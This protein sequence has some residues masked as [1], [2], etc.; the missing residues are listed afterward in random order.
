MSEIGG[1]PERNVAR[2]TLMEARQAS[3]CGRAR[4]ASTQPSGST[5]RPGPPQLRSPM[6]RRR[7][8]TPRWSS[9]GARRGRWSARLRKCAGP[10]APTRCGPACRRQ[11]CALRRPRGCD[12]GAACRSPEIGSSLVHRVHMPGVAA[13]PLHACMLAG[14]ALELC[15]SLYYS[16]RNKHPCC[17]ALPHS[18]LIAALHQSHGML[19]NCNNWQ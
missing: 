2:V 10:R 14:R 13:V 18:L 16:M 12:G 1:Q 4:R 19:P 5:R 8:A 3:C 11:R 9:T 17:Q 7:R 15:A 6:R